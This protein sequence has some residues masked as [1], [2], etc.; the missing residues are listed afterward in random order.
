MYDR[1]CGAAAT[2]QCGEPQREGDGPAPREP[3]PAPL[4]RD[5]SGFDIVKAT[6][7]GAF[8]RVKE[9][10]EAGWDVNQPDHETVTLLH[11]A[12]I[13]NRR[14][15]IEYLLSKGALVDAIGGEL[16]S[17]PLQWAAR[18]GHL[19][20]T[21]A[22]MRAGADPSRRDAEGCASAHLAAQF[23]H[24]AVLAYLVARG[25]SPDVPDA[26]G[27]TP[28]MWAAWKVTSVDPCRLLLSLGAS[29][30]PQDNSHGNTALHW[31]ILAR[32]STA[33]CTLILYGNANLEIP[34]QRG[35]TPLAMLQNNPNA[36]WIGSKVAQKVKEMTTSRSN[37][38]RRITY[39][40]KF[41]W[42]CVVTIPFLAFYITGMVVEMEALYLMK[43]L[44][45]LCFYIVLHFL[46]NFLFDDELKNIFPLSVYLATKMWFYLTWMV[47]IAP[48]VGVAATLGFLASSGLLWHTFLHSW[49]SDP[50]VITASRSDKLRTILE[51]SETGGGAFEAARFCSACL[52]R[53]PLRSKHC[54]VCN[55][56]VAK[57]DHHCPWVANC[58]GAR[59]HRH[60]VGF[61]ISLMAM[62]GWMV[63]GGVQYYQTACPASA[64][65]WPYCNAW[66]AWVL[67][68]AVFHLF[69]VTVLTCCQLYLVVCLGM[70]TNEQLNRGRYRHFQ[71]L[72]GRSPFSRGP[73]NNLADFLQ[74]RLCG[75][76]EPRRT[77]WATAGLDETE[78][79]I[80]PPQQYV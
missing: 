20:A 6:Q 78:P 37:F 74:L 40:R 23:G 19:E 35:V 48:A 25:Q 41:R 68:N 75:L 14:E 51:L 45:L 73:L 50:G 71:R 16:Q 65:S 1:T 66:L 13:N 24:T 4:E 15:I 53:R 7:Y 79:F 58:I 10:V 26:A 21:V 52:V 54:S 30:N 46:T 27:M 8:G 36:I 31:A 49:R 69:W 12:A 64:F 62:C 67:V 22:L 60:F 44:I 39:D 55:R 32:N 77:D 56:C 80:A 38:L 43:L 5:Y 34:N 9:L 70:T 59:N 11:W 3:P 28:L 57:F 17:T 76:A 42:W 47:V 2:G 63:W 72:G 33:I 61:L 18:Q 29:P